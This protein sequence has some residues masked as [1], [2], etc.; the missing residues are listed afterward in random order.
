MRYFDLASSSPMKFDFRFTLTALCL[1]SM[2]LLIFF[3]SHH[4]EPTL[5]TW[6][7][8]MI[9]DSQSLIVFLGVP[10]TWWYIK[11]KQLPEP[12]KWFWVW[13]M[14]WWLV[15]SGRSIS[16]GRD[17]YPEVPHIYFRIISIFLIAPL[18][19]LLFLK[20]LR[21]EI[22]NKLKYATFPFWYLLIAFL[23]LFLAD[24]VEHH[25]FLYH[26]LLD[27]HAL[28]DT[29]EELYE[30]PLIFALFCSAFFFMKQDKLALKQ[31]G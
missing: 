24:C 29:V 10:L 9:E 26:V 5:L 20:P 27:S 18:V 28:Q 31:S 12:Q 6:D 17:F 23:S 19:F 15:L 7:V 2:L 4:Y 11:P 1:V 16:W 30:Y 3:A 14:A 13:S 21:E 8:P 22:W 25:R